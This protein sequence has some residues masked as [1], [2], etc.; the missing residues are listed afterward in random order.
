VN[1]RVVFGWEWSNRDIA[2]GLSMQFYIGGWMVGLGIGPLHFWAEKSVSTIPSVFVPDYSDL[3][4]QIMADNDDE[5]AALKTLHGPFGK[6]EHFRVSLKWALFLEARTKPA[7]TGAKD[8]TDKLL[9]AAAHN[10]QRYQDFLL[11]GSREANRFHV[12]AQERGEIA[13]A[14]NTGQFPGVR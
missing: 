11:E 1:K 10:D 12:L 5:Y 2:V 9:D 8:W 6:W 13:Q 3:L 4:V 14:A 7:P